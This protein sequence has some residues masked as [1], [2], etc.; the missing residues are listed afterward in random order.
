M[1]ANDKQSVLILYNQTGD[2]EYEKLKEVDPA[3]LDFKPVYNLAVATV[4][5]EYAAVADALK[6]EG[7]R[8]KLL[9][10][11]DDFRKLLGA[12]TRR[13]PDVIFNLVEYFRDD[14]ALEGSVAGVLDAS[15][16]PY[17]GAPP[18][19]LILCQRKG[20]TKQVLAGH[21]VPTPHFRI[22]HQQKIGRRH[23]LKYPLIVKPARED[24]SSGV[25]KDSVVYDYPALVAQVAKVFAGFSPPVL[26][27]E[28][29]EGREL[30]VS[31]LG[32]ASPQV[33]PVIEFD[34]SDLPA[35]HPN[36]IS[37]EMKWSP[38]DQS[39]H[40]V[41]SVCPA[42]LSRREMKKVSEA[43]LAAYMLTGC[44]DYARVDMRMNR[45]GEVFVLE[46][47][48]NPDLTA[49]VSYMESAEKAG[50]SFSKTLGMIVGYALGRRRP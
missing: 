23:G 5:E 3:S 29:I 25:T 12:V 34:F 15:G 28:F 20:F 8:A 32:N 39:Y 21:G 30:H 2:D 7:Y 46:V 26:V 22:L 42:A 9:N 35:D 18:G 27:E 19:A 47:N 11:E 49:G 41:H 43:V 44:R 38:L 45:A 37:Y 13:K 17:T 10:I 50:L 6:A 14:P 4:S 48:P 33:L 24:A 1:T 31:V 36:L 40:Q 16:V